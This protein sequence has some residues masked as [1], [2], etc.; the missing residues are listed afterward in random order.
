MNV[1]NI[2]KNRNERLF[3]LEEAIYKNK[4]DVKHYDTLFMDKHYKDKKDLIIRYVNLLDKG[5]VFDLAIAM[6]KA[7][8]EKFYD[9]MKI[10]LEKADL[11][12]QYLKDC[13]IDE[14]KKYIEEENILL[15]ALR[16]EFEHIHKIQAEYPTEIILLLKKIINSGL[17]NSQE[18]VID[19]KLD[20]KIKYLFNRKAYLLNKNILKYYDRYLNYKLFT[21]GDNLYDEYVA[22]NEYEK[23]VENK[24]LDIQRVKSN[25]QVATDEIFIYEKDIEAMKSEYNLDAI[26]RTTIREFIKYANN[27]DMIDFYLEKFEDNLESREL[28][29]IKVVADLRLEFYMKYSK[30]FKESNG[31]LLEQ[32]N[33]IKD[34]FKRVMFAAFEVTQLPL[35]SNIG[36]FENEILTRI[37][38]EYVVRKM[39]S[40]KDF[41]DAD[42]F[43]LL[44]KKIILLMES[45]GYKEGLYTKSQ[46]DVTF[47]DVELDKY[48]EE[49]KVFINYFCK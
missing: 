44:E 39:L 32:I 28:F 48:Y 37:E 34:D 35:F 11:K 14:H 49:N 47:N 10:E 5:D 3:E 41:V 24:S 21:D 36:Y 13:D 8:I 16:S 43:E 33:N 26:K 25:I 17:I 6:R 9:I 38:K 1:H 45:K 7:G 15:E 23:V 40:K 2:I 20:K 4:N 22:F 29:K 31:Y 12:H 46:K 42:D 30:L 18:D 19:Y 27:E